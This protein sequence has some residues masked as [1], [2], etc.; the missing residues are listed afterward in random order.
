MQLLIQFVQRVFQF[1]CG[2]PAC[3]GGWGPEDLEREDPSAEEVQRVAH[4]Q[5][6]SYT[7]TQL[8]DFVWRHRHH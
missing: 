8:L 3:V 4:Y 1:W 5:M 2:C 6:R 7:E